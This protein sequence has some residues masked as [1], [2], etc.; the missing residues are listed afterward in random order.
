L[1]SDLNLHNRTSQTRKSALA[2]ALKKITGEVPENREGGKGTARKRDH[3]AHRLPEC[4]DPSQGARQDSYEK[5]KVAAEEKE[6]RI[7]N[8]QEKTSVDLT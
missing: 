6:N 4:G 2:T 8:R 5:K 7:I 3:A 1:E